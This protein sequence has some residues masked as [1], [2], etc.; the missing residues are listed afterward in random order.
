[1]SVDH[2]IGLLQGTPLRPGRVR[3]IVV[4]PTA[5]RLSTLPRLDYADAFL[6]EVGPA[7]RDRTP[8]Q[9][10]RVILDDAPIAVRSALRSVWLAVGLE[11]SSAR[12]ARSVLGW[13][14]RRSTREFVLLGGS[15]P[16]G[17]SAELLIKRQKHELLFS[18]LLQQRN[19]L[20]RAVWAA[21]EPV[22]RPTVRYVLE[23]GRRR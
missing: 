6:V 22:H 13:E 16:I 5:R 15:S 10:A 11:L 1:M 9:W 19:P 8:E 12:P 21:I 2:A 14:V 4:P 20:A 23:Q 7:A 17:L 18:T 3:Q